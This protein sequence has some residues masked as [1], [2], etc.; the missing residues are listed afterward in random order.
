MSRRNNW[1]QVIALLLSRENSFLNGTQN[2]DSGKFLCWDIN[3]A[4]LVSSIRAASKSH[5]IMSPVKGLTIQKFPYA[6][7]SVFGKILAK[8]DCKLLGD[9]A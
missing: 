9:E 8:A 1:Q 5:E 7:I 4:S 2:C 3:V 6:R